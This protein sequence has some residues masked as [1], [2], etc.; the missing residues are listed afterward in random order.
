MYKAQGKTGDPCAYCGERSESMDHVPPLAYVRMLDSAGLTP[1]GLFLAPACRE[2]NS[3]LGTLLLQTVKE[4]RAHVRKRIRAKYKSLLKT[5]FWSE[6]ELA[7]L[8]PSFA[9]DIRSAMQAAYVVKR[10]LRHGS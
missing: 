6:Q 4:R 5:P 3:I 1:A 7:E 9:D 2:C 8:D 10:R